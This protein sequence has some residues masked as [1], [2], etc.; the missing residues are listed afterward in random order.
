MK[1]K[2]ITILAVLL[3]AGTIAGEWLTKRY[4]RSLKTQKQHTSERLEELR[5]RTLNADKEKDEYRQLADMAK[6]LG[7]AI[8]LEPDSTNILR[9]FAGT[10]AELNL[11]IKKSARHRGDHDKNPSVGIE[12]AVFETIRYSFHVTGPYGALV[13]CVERIERSPHV[14][15]IEGLSLETNNDDDGFG[16]LE[17]TV[18]CLFPKQQS[19]LAQAEKIVG[20]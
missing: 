13:K 4:A 5:I 2:W 17:V 16:R 12:N 8:H 20:K 3:L 18:D 11:K 7:N 15:V 19:S 1:R 14:M 9:W 10:A 6:A